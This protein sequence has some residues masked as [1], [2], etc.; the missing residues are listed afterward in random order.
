[1]SNFALEAAGVVGAERSHDSTNRHSKSEPASSTGAKSSKAQ[2]KGLTGVVQGVIGHLGSK[3]KRSKVKP[4]PEPEATGA[5][6]RIVQ[7][8]LAEYHTGEDNK[9]R[10]LINNVGIRNFFQDTFDDKEAK[11]AVAWA[12]NAYADE[13][14]KQRDLCSCF[15]L[16][17]SEAKRGLC[18]ASFSRLVH[19]VQRGGLSSSTVKDRFAH[20]AGKGHEQAVK[21]ID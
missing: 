5:M 1:M 19:Q 18:L 20:Y 17:K 6:D 16:S 21:A 4:E 12:D 9:G 11:K 14:E 13:M 3:M 2:K 7:K 15:D 8:I 10:P